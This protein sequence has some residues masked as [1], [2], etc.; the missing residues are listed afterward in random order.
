MKSTFLRG[1]TVVAVV[2]CALLF[3]G[4]QF[5]V[6][7]SGGNFL[8][9]WLVYLLIFTGIQALRH[10]GPGVL[11]A[12]AG[13]RLAGAH[14]RLW[15]VLAGVF[16]GARGF[17][18]LWLALSLCYF[19]AYLALFP[20]TF[21]YDGP[22]QAAMFFGDEPLTSHHPL[23]HTYLLGS[24]LQAGQTLF[25]S[26]QAGLA[27]YSALQ[28]LIVTASLAYS[29]FYCVKR[30][31][32]VPLLLVGGLYAALNPFLQILTFSTTKDV[33]FGAFLL[34]LS[35]SLLECLE[36]DV[37]RLSCRV[38]L[39]VFGVLVCLFRNQGIYILLILAV[40][41]LIVRAGKRR[42]CVSLFASL[43]LSEAFFLF[44]SAGLGI[45]KGDSKEMLSVPMQQAA[46]VAW[47]YLNGEDAVMNQEQLAVLEWAIPAE[48]IGAFQYETA[49]PVKSYFYTKGLFKDLPRQIQNYLEI[50]ARNPKAYLDAWGF[51]VRPYWNMK[52]NKYRMLMMKG[53][54]PE[55]NR[56][57]I[58][59]AGLWERYRTYLLGNVESFGEKPLS[60]L[61]R[62]EY[63]LWIL[64][65]L[66]GLVIDRGDPGL[67]LG[68]LPFV[69]YL[70][71][72]L[73]GPMALCRYLFPLTLGTPLLLGLLGKP[74]SGN[75][76]MSREA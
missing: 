25:G 44:C 28:G 5:M 37:P 36:E 24:L 32:P 51:L 3:A 70:G 54:F 75:I 26:F 19:P 76:R 1:R 64:A 74:L 38:R 8:G 63:C 29:I 45:P 14:R 43:L 42:V 71:T 49:D 35:V 18:L 67:F 21:G 22:I 34:C 58:R 46:C 33:P 73:L 48:G 30:G 57:N 40:F 16:C 59:E 39:G 6:Q 10:Y 27:I 65:L 17:L 47:R 2:W 55:L 61:V 12:G 41:C 9:S 11:T 62:P 31:V 60:F 69:L 13:A 20:G 23:A 68:I 7:G 4:F 15:E 72:M 53:T 50:G 66:L 52:F 56:W